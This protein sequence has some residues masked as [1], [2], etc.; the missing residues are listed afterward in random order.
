[1]FI[2]IEIQK[3]TIGE[4]I[5]QK[6]FIIL[7]LPLT[8]F[9]MLL[10]IYAFNG[11]FYMDRFEEYNISEVTRIDENDLKTITTNMIDY[12]KSDRE[13]LEMASMIDGRVQD[14]FGEREKKHMEDV[15]VLFD[16]GLLLRNISVTLLLGS[17]I[18]LISKKKKSMIY[19]AVFKSGVLSLGLITV[20]L[21]MINIDFLKYFTYFHEIFFTNDLWLLDPKTDVLIQMLPLEFF[22]TI[23]TKVVLWFILI[24]LTLIGLAYYGMKFTQNN[25]K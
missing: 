12:L 9:L 3:N 25:L 17:L 10:Q 23:I 14:V 13:N 8:I 11:N 4:L 18:Y 6:Y 16:Y 1:M 22:I 2:S 24:M 19:S 7:F 21:L 20:L 15:K 5:M